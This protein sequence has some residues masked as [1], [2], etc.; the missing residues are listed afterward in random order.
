MLR[1]NRSCAVQLSDAFTWMNTCFYLVGSSSKVVIIVNIIII[2]L[3]IKS[4]RYVRWVVVTC[5]GIC[6][7]MHT[8]Y[9]DI[10]ARFQRKSRFFFPHSK[11]C[12]LICRPWLTVHIFLVACSNIFVSGGCA[13][14]PGY[15]W[16]SITTFSSICSPAIRWRKAKKEGSRTDT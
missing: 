2:V 1:H 4:Y 8:V 15:R 3:I 10:D 7:S 12:C 6:T 5:G 11:Q 14:D 13:L 16:R 9:W